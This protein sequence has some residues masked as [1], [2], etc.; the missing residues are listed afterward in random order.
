MREIVLVSEKDGHML[1]L[2][3]VLLLCYNCFRCTPHRQETWNSTYAYMHYDSN[4]VIASLKKA[5][6]LKQTIIYQCCYSLVSS[7]ALE[8][9]VFPGE[10]SLY[11]ERLALPRD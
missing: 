7:P 10:L 8:V 6:F 4:E 2:Y 9:V 1:L 11:K 3:Y 5:T